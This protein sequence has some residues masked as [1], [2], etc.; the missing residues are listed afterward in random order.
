MLAGA[1]FE[2]MFRVPL[3]P[4]T[5]NATSVTVTVETAA[6]QGATPGTV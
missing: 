4:G 5:G 3:V 2:Q 6:G 1:A